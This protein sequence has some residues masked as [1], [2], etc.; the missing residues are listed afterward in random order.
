M[1]EIGHNGAGYSS[2]LFGHPNPQDSEGSFQ[3][4]RF[5]RLTMNLN[6][7]QESNAKQNSGAK[8]GEFSFTAACYV[9][10]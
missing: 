2:G 4:S 5:K 8:L 10:W 3:P 1:I 6:L 7:F 9:V